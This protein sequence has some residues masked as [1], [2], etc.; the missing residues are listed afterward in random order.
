MSFVP[1]SVTVIGEGLGGEGEKCQNSVEICFD[2]VSFDYVLRHHQLVVVDFTAEWCRPCKR[3]APDINR[4]AIF[5]TDKIKFVQVDVDRLKS[6]AHRYGIHNMPTFLFI[7]NSKTVSIVEG[8]DLERVKRHAD[9]LVRY[10][11][12]ARHQVEKRHVRNVTL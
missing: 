11:K 1:A 5:Y 9:R 8:A 12:A 10:A 7:E 4:L 6:V 2:E 3:I